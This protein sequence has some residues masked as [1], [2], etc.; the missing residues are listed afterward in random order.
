MTL[1][2][3][4]QLVAFIWFAVWGGLIGCIERSAEE[5]ID[6][7]AARFVSDFEMTESTALSPWLRLGVPVHVQRRCP[8][9]PS[10]RRVVTTLIEH[11]A[12]IMRLGGSVS[13]AAQA[14]LRGA[15]STL[16]VGERSCEGACCTWT[17][18][19]VDHGAVHLER[20]CFGADQAGAF[21]TRLE[22][23]DG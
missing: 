2:H 1:G 18:G 13:S 5:S 4:R 9:C 23:T 20:A 19:L 6:S 16:R 14:E 22:L 8:D 7:V 12:D 3:P 11:D 10:A 17:V 21:L 15:V